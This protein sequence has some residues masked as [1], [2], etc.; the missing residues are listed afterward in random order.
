MNLF[1][2]SSTQ[3]CDH[4][5]FVCELYTDLIFLSFSCISITYDS[6]YN[7]HKSTISTILT[8]LF[9]SHQPR[10][11]FSDSNFQHTY[12]PSHSTDADEV[13]TCITLP[14]C[15]RSMSPTLLDYHQS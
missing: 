8:I 9:K 11:L 2:V 10:F 5:V 15:V 13:S 3:P 6:H 1:L 14:D 12:S 4:Q 7:K